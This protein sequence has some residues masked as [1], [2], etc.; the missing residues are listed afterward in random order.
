MDLLSL[1]RQ[2]AQLCAERSRS[3]RDPEMCARWE[4]S[5]LWWTATANILARTEQNPCRG[6]RLKFS[7]EQPSAN[8]TNLT[9]ERLSKRVRTLNRTKETLE[10]ASIKSRLNVILSKH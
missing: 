6:K 2:R 9:K 5:A 4:A 3:A 7:A 10:Q 8:V 1:A